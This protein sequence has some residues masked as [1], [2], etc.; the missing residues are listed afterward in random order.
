MRLTTRA[1]ANPQ[2]G[3]GRSSDG[4]DP[5]LE[6]CGLEANQ[7]AWIVERKE[8]Q[9]QLILEIEG[10]DTQLLGEYASVDEA[11]EKLRQ[12]LTQEEPISHKTT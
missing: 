7:K 12:W 9:Y 1:Y 3:S 6:V 4:D 11:L 2:K 10:R 5:T 8:G